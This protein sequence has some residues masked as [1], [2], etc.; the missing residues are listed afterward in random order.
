MCFDGSFSVPTPLWK[1]F[2][3]SKVVAAFLLSSFPNTPLHFYLLTEQYIVMS[4]RR[5]GSTPAH[6]KFPD[7]KYS[8]EVN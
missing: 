8:R 4:F 6:S 2:Y 3:T 7:D 1:E 5:V